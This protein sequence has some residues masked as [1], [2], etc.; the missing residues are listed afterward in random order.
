V[1]RS[2]FN[3]KTNQNALTVCPWISGLGI[4]TFLSNVQTQNT[5]FLGWTLF[6]VI[7]LNYSLKHS[8][9]YVPAQNVLLH[10]K[11]STTV[12]SNHVSHVNLQWTFHI[13][14][15]LK[16]FPPVWIVLCYRLMSDVLVYV[17]GLDWKLWI[18]VACIVP[19]S[20]SFMI[21]RYVQF[22]NLAQGSGIT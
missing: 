19:V 21:C 13:L 18:F 10:R 17:R 20:R 1:S 7:Y 14:P 15:P 6:I 4:F 22:P 11:F 8:I 5:E 16:I 9:I 12:L 3:L 2:N